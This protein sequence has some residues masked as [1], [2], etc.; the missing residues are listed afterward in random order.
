VRSSIGARLY[1]KGKWVSKKTFAFR[2]LQIRR[3]QGIFIEVDAA[4][5]FVLSGPSAGTGVIAFAHCAR[6]AQRVA[7]DG[8]VSFFP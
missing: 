6:A 3:I 1:P 5:D 7:T 4:F 2:F 8:G